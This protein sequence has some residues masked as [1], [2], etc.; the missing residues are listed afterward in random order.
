MRSHIFS[1]MILFCSISVYSQSNVE[2]LEYWQIIEKAWE[3]NPVANE[4]RL[5]A[6]ATKEKNTIA[7]LEKY[8]GLITK[9]L[10]S[11]LLKLTKEDLAKFIFFVEKKLYEI[12]REDIHRYT[13]G[14]DD[15]FYYA[16]GFILGLGYEHYNL[17]NNN[18]S[19]VAYDVE[20]FE[21]C[22]IGY[23]I[24]K[25]KYG[26][27]FERYQYHNASSFMNKEGWKE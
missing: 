27:E 20:F 24:Y 18:P 23:V 16:R 14:S 15:G 12:D 25:E 17:V 9:S 5:N 26:E 22:F 19:K 3:A 7:K 21:I 6:L 1:L 8:T 10:E 4:A 13:D 11:E 2:D